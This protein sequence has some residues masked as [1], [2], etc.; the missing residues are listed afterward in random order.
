V[1]KTLKT[2]LLENQHRH[3]KSHGQNRA[4]SNSNPHD[5]VGNVQMRSLDW[6]K[7]SV[8]T[9]YAD[10][11]LL[12]PTDQI[13]IVI[14]CDCIYNESLIEP[15]VTTCADICQLCPTHSV[16]LCVVAQQLRSPDIYEAWLKRFLEKFHTWRLPDNI[17]CSSLRENSGF[18]VHVSM[19]R[20]K[21]KKQ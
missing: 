14:A 1:L 15:F 13:D 4:V 18:V 9:L 7:D 19:L 2:N 12:L 17:V 20:D 16:T 3:S 5:R 6:E 10:L 21:N 8:T 11:G